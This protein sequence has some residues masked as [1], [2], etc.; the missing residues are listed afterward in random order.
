MEE[1]TTISTDERLEARLGRFHRGKLWSSRMHEYLNL[2]GESGLSEKL[3][4]CGMELIFERIEEE[5]EEIHR[6]AAGYFCKNP[7]ICPPCAI[8]R[9][10][11]R[12]RVLAPK[13]LYAMK[14]NQLPL[15]YLVTVT[16]KNGPDMV[17]RLNHLRDAMRRMFK[18]RRVVLNGGRGGSES[19]KADGILWTVE[20]KR[21]GSSNL[22]HPHAHMVWLCREEIDQERLSEEWK[23]L[24]GDSYIVDARPFDFC[25]ENDYS[26]EA[27]QADIIEVCKYP[28]KFGMS[29]NGEISDDE[30]PYSDAWEFHDK[31]RGARLSDTLGCLR[32][33]KEE[34]EKMEGEIDEP[35]P[36]LVLERI[37]YRWHLTGYQKIDDVISRKDRILLLT[38]RNK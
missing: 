19:A 32:L 22:W 2:K 3:R 11:K 38:A 26:P 14:E 7:K 31:T 34:R 35:S 15:A 21:G 4:Q 27:V 12:V 10:S 8:A 24:T 33:S 17:E 18:R 30:T 23:N 25:V 13:I 28:G 6:L 20:V 5:G 9:S 37:M 16:V 1:L 29:Q 36:G